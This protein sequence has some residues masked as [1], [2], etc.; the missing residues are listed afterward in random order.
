MPKCKATSKNGKPCRN[1][2]KGTCG[3]CGIHKKYIV[4]TDRC[5]PFYPKCTDRCILRDRNAPIC[6]TCGDL[7]IKTIQLICGHTIH[8]ICTKKWFMVCDLSGQD[9]T[10]PLCRA[11]EK[12]TTFVKKSRC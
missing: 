2:Y 9:Q 5:C 1:D 6:D 11:V 4:S 12:K 3:Y 8:D 10:C 7:V